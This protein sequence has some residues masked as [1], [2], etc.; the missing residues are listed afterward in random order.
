MVGLELRQ[1]Q[2]IQKFIQHIM[3]L[4]PLRKIDLLQLGGIQIGV[5]NELQQIQSIQK[6]I[7][8]GVLL[9]L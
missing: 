3:P 9:L 7:Q 6:Y 5:G 2:D 4:L 8:I 1:I